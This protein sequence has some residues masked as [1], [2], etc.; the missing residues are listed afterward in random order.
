[1][2][3][4][5]VPKP[6][7]DDEK[8]SEITEAKSLDDEDDSKISLK[9]HTKL[10]D[11]HDEFYIADLKRM[12]YFENQLS[13]RWN[14]RN[15]IHITSDELNFDVNELKALLYFKQRGA[16]PAKYPYQRLPFLCHALDYFTE[17]ITDDTFVE[18]FAA[19][20]PTIRPKELHA[21][22]S[23][24][25]SQECKTLSNAINKYLHQI[26]GI[27]SKINAKIVNNWR[28]VSSELLICNEYIAA[29]IFVSHFK[30]IGRWMY[31]LSYFLEFAEHRDA[32]DLNLLWNYISHHRLY[33]HYPQIIGNLFSLEHQSDIKISKDTAQTMIT[34][35][36]DVID[37]VYRE[38]KLEM[39]DY[40]MKSL[41]MNYYKIIKDQKFEQ[42][43]SE[44]CYDF[45]M[46]VLKK[47]LSLRMGN[48]DLFN[49]TFDIDVVNLLVNNFSD[50]L[51]AILKRDL[52]HDIET[53]NQLLNK[54][55]KCTLLKLLLENHHKMK[56]EV[57]QLQD[58]VKPL[59]E[60]DYDQ[61]FILTILWFPLF[62][63]THVEWIT[64]ELPNETSWNALQTLIFGISDYIASAQYP[65]NRCPKVYIE[66][67][68]EF[69]NANWQI[70]V[71]QHK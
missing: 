55:E 66:F 48:E 56:L 19:H 20:I 3:D 60:V 63:N 16:M 52:V 58:I 43:T 29:S 64:K 69:T 34:I 50:M 18:Y 12:K 9:M 1:M 37:A 14:N 38:T 5:Q 44:C 6:T 21:F 22:K 36:L 59:I 4:E 46:E 2:A 17:E 13:G 71:E 47:L 65:H 24:C 15:A 53:I 26:T 54:E 57:K 68:N 32:K 39:K 25:Q 11:S 49:K 10:G 42:N 31:Q 45:M 70:N 41:I 23:S 27:A 40:K 30:L 51:T 33:L 67:I 62:M 61:S 35:T 28:D 8:A 7:N